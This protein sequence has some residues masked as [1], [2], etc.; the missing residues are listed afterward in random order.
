MQPKLPVHQRNTCTTYGQGHPATSAPATATDPYKNTADCSTVF[1]STRTAIASARSSRSN[2]GWCRSSCGPRPDQ[3]PSR[4]IAPG[5]SSRYHEK[6]SPPP[7]CR[8]SASTSGPTAS[9]A[10]IKMRVEISSFTTGGTPRRYC[11]E[12]SIPNGASSDATVSPTI[13]SSVCHVSWLAVRIVPDSVP[14]CGIAFGATPAFTAP[15]TITVL[16]RGSIR[17]DSTP[18]RPVISVP[19]PYTKSAVR[20]GLDVC[21]PGEYNVISMESAADVIGPAV[22]ATLPTSNRGSQCSAKIL[23][24]PVSTP[25]AIA[26][27]APPGISS[28]AGWKMNRTPTGR[29]ETGAN[30]S[31]VP[32]KIAVCAS[33]PQACA[34]PGTTEAYWAPVRSDIGSPSMSARSAILGRWSGPRPHGSPVPAGKA[35][36]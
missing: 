33:C 19:M 36:G 7:D 18:G 27:I 14:F 10:C 15:Q 21:P 25:A 13:D 20:C 12:C 16:L 17:R 5:T 30:A 26:P 1:T 11:S 32:N 28:S 22:T 29:S 23:D 6:S 8:V 2:V 35:F 4:A 9:I 3:P 24:T 34:T 31:A